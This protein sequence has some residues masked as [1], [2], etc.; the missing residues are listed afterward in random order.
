VHASVLDAYAQ[1]T[2]QFLTRMLSMFEGTFA[3]CMYPCSQTKLRNNDNFEDL[4][5]EVLDSTY[6]T[7]LR[8]HAENEHLNAR[9]IQKRCINFEHILK[10]GKTDYFTYLSLSLY[11]V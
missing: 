3:Q 2:H 5:I 6:S 10:Q 9:K 4:W 11:S 7:F 8:I 1:F